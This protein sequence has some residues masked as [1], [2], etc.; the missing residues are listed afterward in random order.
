MSGGLKNIGNMASQGLNSLMGSGQEKVGFLEDMA[1]VDPEKFPL[2]VKTQVGDAFEGSTAARTGA[3]II[4]PSVNKTFDH[5]IDN[6]M[7]GKG[8]KMLANPM[9]FI[10]EKA[11]EFGLGKPFSGGGKSTETPPGVSGGAS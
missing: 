5:V 4:A 9:D 6:S 3:D 8:L 10:S 11:K 7:F 1:K 2:N